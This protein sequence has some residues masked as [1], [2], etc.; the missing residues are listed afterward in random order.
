M[1]DKD[2]DTAA[3]TSGPDGFDHP[4]G[5]TRALDGKVAVVTGGSRGIGLGIATQFIAEGATVFITARNQG[6]L[7]AARTALG[8]RLVGVRADAADLNGLDL[9]FDDIRQRFGR[10]DVLVANAGAGSVAP[11]GHITE[12]QFDVVFGLNVKGTLFAAQKA[13]PLMGPGSSIVLIGSNTSVQ[14]S[15]SLSVYA[16]TKAALRSFA[17]TWVMDLRGRGIRVNVLSPGPTQTPGLS[18]LAKPGHLQDLLD[19]FSSR[20]PLGR[21]G[22]PD[23]I[24]KAAVFLASDASSFVTG[25]EL[26]VDGGYAQ[27]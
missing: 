11:L 5:R 19:G 23:E 9:L 25:T 7:D 22:Q 16:A 6:D 8:E 4:A 21:V 20:V 3:Q 18:G 2:L 10:L 17:R 13:L 15:P 26:F 24:G 14:G 1:T 27:V 12:E